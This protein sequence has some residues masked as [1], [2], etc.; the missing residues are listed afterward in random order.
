MSQPQQQQQQP[1]GPPYAPDIA[2]VGGL[3]DVMPDIPVCAAL[4]V[5]YVAFA[6]T[7]MTIFQL[8]RR[9]GHKFVMSGMLFGF[10]MSRIV[11]LVLRIAWA[12]RQANVRLSIAATIFVNAGVLLLYI[13]NLIFAQRL[14]RARQP[15]LGW[16][17]TL[18]IAFRAVYAGI[19][20]A[21]ACL[22][23][24]VVLGAYTL[25][26]R[27]LR[28]TRDVELAAVTYMLVF[29]AL[30]LVL[31]A[32]AHGLLPR[33]PA[34]ER[35]GHGSMRFK[36]GLLALT[37][38]LCVL[39]AGFNAGALW[40]PP[41]PRDDPAWYQ[42]KP[43]FYCFHFAVEITVLAL[44]T[45]SR[46]DRRFHIPDGSSKP[47]DYSAGPVASLSLSDKEGGAGSDYHR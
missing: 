24:A 7:N 40:A 32:L 31:L 15:A 25:D 26:A 18:G 19:G 35:F 37:T 27:T 1:S 10:C 11:S 44:F 34:A 45:I 42:S 47:G 46:V 16:H 43:A 30:P 21:L 28:Q 4:I 5:V 13:V 2:E 41:R 29:A 38:S 12:T 22:V 20:A 8:N 6:A 39:I 9:R 14:L 3:P 36:A 33:H 23:V 17:R